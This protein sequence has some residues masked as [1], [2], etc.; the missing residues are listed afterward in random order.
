[1]KKTIVLKFGGSCL[2]PLSPEMINEL[3]NVENEIKKYKNDGYNVIAVVS[4]PKGFT[5][6][7]HEI[8][9]SLVKDGNH[10]FLDPILGS[11]EEISTKTLAAYLNSK[12]IK[13]EYFLENQLPILTNDKFGAANI[14]DVKTNLI[15]KAFSNNSVVICPGY[16]GRTE[17]GEPT[18]IG[19]DGS[20]TTAVY[21]TSALK[22]E[23][24]VLYKDVEGV[25]PVRP[26]HIS[27]PIKPFEEISLKDMYYYSLLGARIVHP[28]SIEE[29]TK[30][31]LVIRVKSI[32]GNGEG[33]LISNAIK[34]K[35]VIG[36]TYLNNTVNLPSFD[37]TYLSIIG[38][39]I[40]INRILP[41]SKE[42]DCQKIIGIVREEL[43]EKIEIPEEKFK[44]IF[45][46]NGDYKEFMNKL[47]TNLFVE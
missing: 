20:D 24:C 46:D 47:Y 5:R 31:D 45:L 32:K 25:Y 3:V 4:A 11:G 39:D 35:N 30:K 10:K 44:T 22:A 42:I 18:T 15:K 38:K 13:T 40:N 28:K 9:L 2:G 8:A 26:D 33:T 16:I 36:I 34:N 29:A 27:L 7:L 21:L 17:N 14:I 1:M 12:N 6:Q 37:G 19:F 23:E 43:Q 41:L